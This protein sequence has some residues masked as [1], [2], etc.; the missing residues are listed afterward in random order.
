[1]PLSLALDKAGLDCPVVLTNTVRVA[2]GLWAG[3]VN[4][5][6]NVYTV[7]TG[8]ECLPDLV[9]V[10]ND[11]VGTT[12]V[13]D[14]LRLLERF[15]PALRAAQQDECKGV[16]ELITY[17]IAYVNTGLETATH[18]VLTETLPAYT[19]YAGTGWNHA[20]GDV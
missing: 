11:N 5:A 19:S 15:A 14:K 7:T 8:F 1:M 18:V 4:P 10:K 12:P 20:G 13:G 6:D 9:V 2:D 17:T 3:D 16:G